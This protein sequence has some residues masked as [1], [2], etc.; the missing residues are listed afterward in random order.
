MMQKNQVVVN[1]LRSNPA[2]KFF[3]NFSKVFDIFLGNR[4]I[5]P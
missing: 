2:N 3:K 5:Y 4:I 1:K